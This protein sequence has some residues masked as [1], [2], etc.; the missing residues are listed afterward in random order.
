MFIKMLELNY[1]ISIVPNSKYVIDKESIEGFELAKQI[2]D[3]FGQV[4]GLN[5]RG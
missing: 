5:Q 2:K 4:I 3:E 1:M